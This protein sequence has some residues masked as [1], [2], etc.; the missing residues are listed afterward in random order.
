MTNKEIIDAIFRLFELLTSWPVIFLAAVL[1]FYREIKDAIPGLIKRLRKAPGGWEFDELQEVK[2][3]LSE[4]VNKREIESDKESKELK[5]DPTLIT[6][7]H[8]SEP[9]DAK[10]WRVKVTL[11]APDGFVQQIEKVEFERH[12]TFKNKIKIVHAPPFVDSFKCWGAFTIKASIYLR[13]GQIL[14]RQR[15]LTLENNDD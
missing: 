11:E 1:I 8:T 6:L 7:S 9:A 15:F 3:E 13:D 5:V 4:L 10:Y 12:Q 2:E 14:R